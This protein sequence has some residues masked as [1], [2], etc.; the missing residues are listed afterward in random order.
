MVLGLKRSPMTK[1]VRYWPTSPSK[2]TDHTAARCWPAEDP[3]G[4]S[5]SR[6][7][8]YWGLMAQDESWEV[9]AFLVYDR[10]ADQV[11]IRDMRGV[12]GVDEDVDPV[13][14]VTAQGPVERAGIPSSV[15]EDRCAGGVQ[16]GDGIALAHVGDSR[17]YRLRRDRL[18]VLTE[19]HSWV[20]EQVAAG[21]LTELLGKTN[22]VRHLGIMVMGLGLLFFGMA[23][24]SSAMR[25]SMR[26]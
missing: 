7:R 18:E 13:D 24:M 21:F 5:P 12:P 8:R 14:P 9:V 1:S 2:R 25:P 15:D 4:R 3:N 20:H 16:E 6:D 17:A 10:R 11:T 22:R 19:D 26:A 23:L